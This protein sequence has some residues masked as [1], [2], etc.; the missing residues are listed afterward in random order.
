MAFLFLVIAGTIQNTFFVLAPAFPI[1]FGRVR[2][3]QKCRR[4]KSHR[5]APADVPGPHSIT[6]EHVIPAWS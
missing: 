5:L 6:P 3:D 2:R 1:F 4:H